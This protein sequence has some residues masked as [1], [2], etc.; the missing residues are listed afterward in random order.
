MWEV[1]VQE[2]GMLED[3]PERPGSIAVSS[4]HAPGR[5]SVPEPGWHWAHRQE[6]DVVPA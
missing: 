3:N 5:S 1:H 2:A 4:P 6:K